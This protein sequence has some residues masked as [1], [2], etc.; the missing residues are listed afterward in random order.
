VQGSAPI[1]PQAEGGACATSGVLDYDTLHGPRDDCPDLGAYEYGG[2]TDSDGVSSVE[3]SNGPGTLGPLDPGFSG[4]NQSRSL[5]DTG[6]GN[7]DG[8][9][10]SGQTD[11]T[12]LLGDKGWFTLHM[13]DPPDVN[14]QSQLT[15]VALATGVGKL[16]TNLG[17][18]DTSLGGLSFTASFVGTEPVEFDLIAPLRGS[19]GDMSLIKQ[20]C[21]A[22]SASDDWIVLDG[23]AEAFGADRV[24]FSFEIE[25]NGVLDCDDDPTTLSD[26]SYVV[27]NVQKVVP[28]PGLSGW[29]L[30]V[31]A[32][33]AALLGANLARRGRR[34]R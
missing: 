2:D 11:V 3:E 1:N 33:L 13:T 31:L 22:G 4:L 9:P 32:G 7:S 5:L 23:E 12:T 15:N 6:D 14:G 30:G 16:A 24:R 29:M 10:D 18:F 27:S 19:I 21:D 20:Q 8:V 26:P 17:S 25:P 34:A 28:V